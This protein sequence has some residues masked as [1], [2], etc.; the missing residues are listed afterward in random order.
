MK[1]LHGVALPACLLMGCGGAPLRAAEPC[2]SAPAPKPQTT[3]AAAPREQPRSPCA[4]V[5]HEPKQRCLAPSEPV[6]DSPFANSAHV[7]VLADA[8]F[9]ASA[10][11]LAKAVVERCITR[12]EARP[13]AD[14]SA[15]HLVFHAG[16][17]TQ[18]IIA[19]DGGLD[20]DLAACVA[21]AAYE[22]VASR[23]GAPREGGLD[24]VLYPRE[25]AP[26]WVA[27]RPGST[28]TAE[29]KS[30]KG[31]LSSAMLDAILEPVADLWI[32]CYETAY[33][34]GG[35]RPRLNADFDF[36]IARDGH[37]AVARATDDKTQSAGATM[38][39]AFRECLARAVYARPA[40]AFDRG[41]EGVVVA[42]YALAFSP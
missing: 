3:V 4:G 33:P 5:W 9:D 35:P 41:F 6:A 14:G 1:G 39:D 7:L 30:V 11:D 19:A 31:Q 25:R 34:A 23:D 18:P 20:D 37:Y 38:T 40:I 2:P 21:K 8:P 12:L 22:T 32:G 15:I 42:S 16:L 10:D 13:F 27:T 36:V 29:A 28:L 26:G 17:Q 24:V